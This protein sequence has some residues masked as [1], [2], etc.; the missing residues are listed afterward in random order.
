MNI[1][2]VTS[3]GGITAWLVETHAVPVLSL[4]FCFEGGGIQAPAGKE[5]LGNFVA[6]MLD[7]GAGPYSGLAFKERALDLGA[8]IGFSCGRDTFAGSLDVLSESRDAAAQLLRLAL[9]APRLES[10]AADRIRQRLQVIIARAAREPDK[11]ASAQWDAIAFAGHPYAQSALGTATSIGA[12]TTDDLEVYRRRVFA[13]DN[14]KVVAVGDIG[15]DAL[16]ALLDSVFA[17][18]PAAAGLTSVGDVA[19]LPR[20]RQAIVEIDVPQSSVAFGLEAMG[21]RD[22]DYMAAV[23]LNN[24]VGGGGFASRLMEEVR[25]KRGLAYGVSTGLSIARH[26]AVW[27]GRVATRNELVGQSI[28]VIGSELKKV[29]R[30]AIAARDLEN[31]QS[32]LTGSYPLRFDANGKIAGELMGLR[33]EG[34][35][36]EYVGQRNGLINA[37]TLEDLHRVAQRLFGADKLI[38]AIAGKPV[39]GAGS[40][41]LA[42]SAA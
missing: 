18:L 35:G 32:Y 8:R 28:E 26:A 39:L 25:V 24:I 23:V 36:P 38:V 33:I 20:G 4:R 22:A 31:A 14:L 2:C 40:A 9:T 1:Q 15:A 12:I 10:D 30:G 29:A 5:G 17:D 21:P 13:R 7:E 37:V 6:Q 34:L 3:P 19:S 27:R 11:V 41:G 16:G 42:T